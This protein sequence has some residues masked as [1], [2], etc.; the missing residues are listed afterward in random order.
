[1]FDLRQC[2]DPHP[3]QGICGGK[4]TELKV[5]EAQ[6]SAWN[7]LRTHCETNAQKPGEVRASMMAQHVG[8]QQASTL[9][10]RLDRKTV[11]A[12]SR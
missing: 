10:D 6:A 5:T 1:M 11:A 7:A 2:A 8:Q 9:A 3:D 12:S 4:R